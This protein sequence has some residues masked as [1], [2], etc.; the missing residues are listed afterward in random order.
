MTRTISREDLLAKIENKQPLM[1][2]EALPERYY[3]EGHLPG[4]V[5]LPHDRVRELGPALLADKNAA[6]VTY[7]ASATCQNSHIAADT[8]RAMG[9]TNVSVYAE[10]KQG[11]AEAGLTLETGLPGARAA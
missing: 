1:L 3:L 11:W 7:C 6:I 10:G 9:Y 8:L 2:I 5:H 4:A